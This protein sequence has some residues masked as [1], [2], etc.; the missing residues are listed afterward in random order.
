M[1]GEG[2]WVLGES[3]SPPPPPPRKEMRTLSHFIIFFILI[4]LVRAYAPTLPLLFNF[5]FKLVSVETGK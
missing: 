3:L 1:D 2:G 5:V 4:W